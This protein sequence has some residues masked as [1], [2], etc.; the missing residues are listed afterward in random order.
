MTMRHGLYVIGALPTH[1][2]LWTSEEVDLVK[3]LIDIFTRGLLQ[4]VPEGTKLGAWLPCVM[5]CTKRRLLRKAI[6]DRQ[7]LSL[8][9]AF[10]PTADVNFAALT[11][12]LEKLV[13]D[14]L[15]TAPLHRQRGAKKVRRCIMA[16]EHASPSMK[17]RACSPP[18]TMQDTWVARES[19]SASYDAMPPAV[20]KNDHQPKASPFELP[21]WCSIDLDHFAS[22]DDDVAAEKSL[23]LELDAWAAE[24]VQ[25]IN[26]DASTLL[27]D[28]IAS[29]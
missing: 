2:G 3:F 24:A 9:Y 5:N 16:D 27:L 20:A 19:V 25:W 4:N 28:T 23:V 17:L 22:L 6:A 1:G 11:A 13:A 18:A 26:V 29:T 15:A 7:T 8:V 14:F 10:K 12:T 21:S